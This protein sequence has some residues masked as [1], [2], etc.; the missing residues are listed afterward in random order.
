MCIVHAYVLTIIIN[1]FYFYFL[2]NFFLNGR[3]IF[4]VKVK[5]LSIGKLCFLPQDL[6]R[7][8]SLKKSIAKQEALT[9]QRVEKRKEAKEVCA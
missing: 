1:G 2:L 4:I 8:K 3:T 5:T 6:F 9:A 7:M